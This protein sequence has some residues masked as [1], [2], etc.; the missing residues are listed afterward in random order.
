MKGLLHTARFWFQLALT[1]GFLA[2][3]FW[4]LGDITDVQAAFES[5]ADAEWAWVPLALL[6]FT[7]SKLVH[8]ARWRLM[9]GRHR[10]IPFFGLAGIFLV[11]NMANAVLLLR[12][13]DV[14]RIQ[15]T[16][17]RY[18]ISRSELTATVIVVE[19]LLDG[20]AFVLLLAAAFSL[21][22]VPDVLR[23][24]FWA[25]AGLAVVGLLLGIGFAQFVRAETLERVYPFRWLSYDARQGFRRLV[26]QFQEGMRAL[27]ESRVAVPVALLS[28]GGWALE[29]CAYWAFGQAFDLG[30]NFAAYFIIMMTANFAVSIPLT[31][32]GIGPYE[33]ATQEVMYHLGVPRAVATGY[34]I[35]IH[36][37]F[38][39]W[40]TITGLAA[41]WLM[42]LSPSEIFYVSGN[43]EEDERSDAPAPAE[44]T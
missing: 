29:G 28:L 4:R 1:A 12:A 33:V 3:L 30:L 9:L 32:S 5:L 25:V 2:L 20:F 27:R 38:I 15:T 26:T 19:S 10:K 6:I 31:P 39:I 44:A 8:T 17:R 16:S 22:E 36:L 42:K 13:G 41:M 21:G 24:T 18:G 43:A 7:G 14:V 34:A 35:A 11:H 37:C 23:G 40:V